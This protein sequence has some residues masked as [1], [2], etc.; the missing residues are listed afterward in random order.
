MSEKD[1]EA[2]VRSAVEEA[3]EGGSTEGDQARPI[4]VRGPYDPEQYRQKV[5]Q[6]LILLLAVLI[7]GHYTSTLVLAWNAKTI[8]SLT[9]V[10]NTALP[11]VAGLTGSAV[12]YYFTRGGSK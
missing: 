7:L 8:E 1:V 5:T 3:I 10:Y 6:R 4:K 11:V 12:T 9:N 2:V